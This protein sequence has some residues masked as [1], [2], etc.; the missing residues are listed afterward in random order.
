MICHCWAI[1]RQLLTTQYST[2]PEGNHRNMK[3]KMIGIAII[4]FAWMGSGGVGLSFICT[5]IDTPMMIG[6]MK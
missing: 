5:I 6:R 4:T 3:V 1:D 2:S